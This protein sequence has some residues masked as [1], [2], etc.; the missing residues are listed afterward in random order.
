[1]LR[2]AVS[3]ADE[4]SGQPRHENHAA[5]HH[6]ADPVRDKLAPSFATHSQSM[7]DGFASKKIGQPRPANFEPK[8]TPANDSHQTDLNKTAA[9]NQGLLATKSG[10]PNEQ[11][12]R[13]PAGAPFTAPSSGDARIRNANAASFGGLAHSSAKNS[14]AALNGTGIKRKL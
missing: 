9:L 12:A 6:S 13:L 2:L 8:H 14:A 1:M 11:L 3:Y 7:N 4:P 5:I 10:T